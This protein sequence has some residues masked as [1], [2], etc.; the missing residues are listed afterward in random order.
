MQDISMCKGFPHFHKI[1]DGWR[2]IHGKV[3]VAEGG[4]SLWDNCEEACP[5]PSNPATGRREGGA[6]WAVSCVTE[7]R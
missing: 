4:L 1:L 3:T 5:G 7:Q 6:P 2:L